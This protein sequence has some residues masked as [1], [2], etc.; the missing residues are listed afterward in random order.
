MAVLTAARRRK[1]PR[2]SFAVPK[3]KG[4]RPEKNSYPIHDPAHA[5]NALARVAQHGSP[6]EQR[7]V[8][9]AVARR[10]PGIAVAGKKKKGKKAAIR[11]AFTRQART[12][13]VA[14]SAAQLAVIDLAVD[15]GYLDLAG[16]WRHGW[17]PL[18]AVALLSKRKGKP[19]GSLGHYHGGGGR[20]PQVKRGTATHALGTGAGKAVGEGVTPKFA[21]RRALGKGRAGEAVASITLVGKGGRT[22]STRT[23][24]KVDKLSTKGKTGGMTSPTPEGTGGVDTGSLMRSRTDAQVQRLAAQKQSG[25]LA[26]L[27]RTEAEKRGL[28]PLVHI[29]GHGLHPTKKASEVKVGDTRVYNGPTAGKVTK[30][31][32]KG[33]MVHITTDQGG[34]EYTTKHKPSTPLATKLGTAEVETGFV[35]KKGTNFERILGST[36]ER[37]VT[38]EARANLARTT[39]AAEARRAEQ[40]KAPS[41]ARPEARYFR[42]SKTE[43][44]DMAAKGDAKASAELARREAKRAKLASAGR[45]KVEAPATALA[46]RRELTRRAAASTPP[47]VRRSTPAP[48]EPSARMTYRERRERRAER[49]RGWAEKRQTSAAAVFEAGRPF[50]SDNAFNTQPGHIPFRARLIARED[51]AHESVRKAERMHSRAAG[52][53]SQLAGAIYSDDPHAIPALRDRIAKLEAQRE[54]IKA[55]NAAYRKEHKAE[56]AKLTAYGRDRALPHPSYELT[57]LGGNISRQKKRLAELERKAKP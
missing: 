55:R 41:T 11:G 34:T 50:T 48:A 54:Q 16:K 25:L 6:F 5:R 38:P 9:A 31:E 24:P 2:S 7:A 56:L 4:S 27:A 13:G 29:Q 17:I 52:I 42:A 40:A 51:R 30:V 53:E 46:R 32:T 14:L 49:L 1:L 20:A 57:N 28:P 12:R 15:T 19:G 43:L 45:P 39:A 35:E 37:N 21:N 8:R 22:K 10:Y 36:H 33:N 23:P 44:Q 18:D 26:S 47:V 3:G